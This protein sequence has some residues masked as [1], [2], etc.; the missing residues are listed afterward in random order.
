MPEFLSGKSEKKVEYL[1]LI[2]DLIFVYIIGRNNSLLHLLQDGFI[3]PGAYL[4]YLCTTLIVL[5]IW[6]YTTLFINR[7][8]TNGLAEHIATFINMY[9][10]YYMADSTR[11][12]W[13]ALY[14]RYNAAWALILLN[15]AV[16]YAI[17]LKKS[18]GLMP[19]E[20]AHLK[21]HMRILL[22]QSALI[23]ATIPLHT[24]TGLPLA[25][26]TVPLAMLAFALA[27]RVNRL[28]LVDF[29]HLTERVMLYV[30]F[31]FGEMI[32]GIA[33]YFEGGFS[34]RSV[35]F[36][37]MGFLI[38]VGL[39][40]S[41]GFMYDHL[42][43]RHRKTTGT[44]Y[45][46]LHIFLIAALSN[47]TVALEFMQ[48]AQVAVVPKH[49]FLVASLLVYFFFLFMT[50]IY[51]KVRLEQNRRFLAMLLVIFALFIV[52][53]AVLYRNAVASIALT[54]AFIYALYFLIFA[55]WRKLRLLEDDPPDDETEPLSHT[56]ET[57]E[58]L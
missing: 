17:K 55:Y 20:D 35:Y 16:Q 45:M 9:L 41:Y 50:E 49:V 6:F 58:T 28:V 1:E 39:F 18:G 34:F 43:D 23:L 33:G 51:A 5:Q 25:F 57:Q 37:L 26:V 53:M 36:S 19:W 13:D 7:Y 2:Y 32:I 22:A 56:N 27:D 10:L 11:A 47:I 44:G 46:F 52:L 42:L 3:R 12:N 30:V 15:L 40:V 21:L 4:T 8:G 54:V 38:V 24:A 48:E 14:V 29:P 31:T